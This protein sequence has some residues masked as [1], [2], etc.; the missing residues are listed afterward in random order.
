MLF[1]ALRLT[2]S[3]SFH[4]CK[5]YGE[6]NSSTPDALPMA[7]R[8]SMTAGCGVLRRRWSSARLVEVH[9]ANGVERRLRNVAEHLQKAEEFQQGLRY[10]PTF[11]KLPVGAEP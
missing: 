4:C 6:V 11:D 5:E 8:V 3:P 2:L 9:W 7:I 1:R 10:G